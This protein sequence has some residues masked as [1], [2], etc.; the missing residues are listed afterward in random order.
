VRLRVSSHEREI[1]RYVLNELLVL[2]PNAVYKC[3]QLGET[4]LVLVVPGR[5]CGCFRLLSSGGAEQISWGAMP[6]IWNS[7]AS[8]PTES[9]IP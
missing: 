9:V 7:L 4:A 6:R 1:Y 8:T 5:Y 3:Y 2:Y